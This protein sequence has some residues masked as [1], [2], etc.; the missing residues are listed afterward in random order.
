MFARRSMAVGQRA[1]AA[2]SVATAITAITLSG[3]PGTDAASLRYLAAAVI[4][5]VWTVALAVR[6]RTEF[7]R[8]GRLPTTP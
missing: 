6:L 8:R 2:Y 1:S 7:A 4:V 3:W 5:W